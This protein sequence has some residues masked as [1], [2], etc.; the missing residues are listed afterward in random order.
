[1]V[2]PAPRELRAAHVWAGPGRCWSPGRVV[3]DA[4]GVVRAVGPARG[5]R[6]VEPWLL[7]PG[8][9][10][11]HAH[12]QLASLAGPR[13]FL[14]WLRAVIASR[15]VDTHAVAAQTRRSA[16][17]LLRQGCTAVAEMDAVGNSPGVLAEL[18]VA[19]R[20]YQEVLGF[21]LDATSA[22]S[23]LHGRQRSPQRRS[24]AGLAPHAPYSCSTA[25]LRAAARA[26]R[27]LSVHIAEHEAELELLRDG[28]GP[29]RELLED[30]GRWP[31]GWRAP[32]CSPVEWLRRADALRADTLLV[33]AQHVSAADLAAIAACQASVAVCPPTLDYFGRQPPPVARWLRAGINVALGTDSAAS[34]EGPLSM[35]GVMA[36]ARRMWPSL[37]PQTVL[38]M[39]TIRA[40]RAIA[41]PS[42]GAIRLGAPADLCAFAVT[43]AAHANEAIDAAT[44]GAA[45]VV[46]VWSAGLAVG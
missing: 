5:A 14:A 33:H 19:G 32:G 11:A 24:W 18:G 44:A 27:P 43:S 42:L 40:A 35:P 16:L 39:A 7:T 9:V 3:I 8:L 46:G 41:C 20:C 25:L 26:R 30:L 1:M 15:R 29:F 6:G 38:A 36:Q 31:A 2:Q 10:N 4:R 12:L 13:D 34:C 37:H 21:T 23:L 22:R 17:E 28:R 45:R